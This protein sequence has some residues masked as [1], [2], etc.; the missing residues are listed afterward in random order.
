MARTEWK[1]RQIVLVSEDGERFSVI[2]RVQHMKAEGTWIALDRTT[3]YRTSKGFKVYKI[4][5]YFE[6]QTFFG[7]IVASEISTIP[8]PGKS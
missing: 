1:E 6:I 5:D 8:P 2:E 4:E 7:P 3:E